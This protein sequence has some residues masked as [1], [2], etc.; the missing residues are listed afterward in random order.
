METCI[1]C[2]AKAIPAWF[3]VSDRLD[4]EQVMVL[5]VNFAVILSNCEP[6]PLPG[7]GHSGSRVFCAGRAKQREKARGLWNSVETVKA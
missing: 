2:G 3:P 1:T 5:S 4:G 6:M 7:T